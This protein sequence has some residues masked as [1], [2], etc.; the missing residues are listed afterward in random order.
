MEGRPAQH[1]RAPCPAP[2]VCLWI[3]SLQ[4]E[5]EDPSGGCGP[6]LPRKRYL[7]RAWVGGQSLLF[8]LE[9]IVVDG[10]L[11]GWRRLSGG[12]WIFRL[13]VTV[14]MD[15]GLGYCASLSLTCLSGRLPLDSFSGSSCTVCLPQ[16]MGL[17]VSGVIN[18]SFSLPFFRPSLS[19]YPPS[20]LGPSLSASLLG[21]LQ[22][23]WAEELESRVRERG[24]AQGVSEWDLG[25]PVLSGCWQFRCINS[26]TFLS[27]GRTKGGECFHWGHTWEGGRGRWWWWE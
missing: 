12:F 15:M 25:R 24:E 22:A 20:C 8:L 13:G 1:R 14:Q 2:V 11:G 17:T 26:L 6:N 7:Q 16:T 9:G 18:L 3:L 4:A 21:K 10:S 5:E 19:F 23:L 27:S